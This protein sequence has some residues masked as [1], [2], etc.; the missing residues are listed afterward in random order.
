M[1]KLASEGEALLQDCIRIAAKD[2]PIISRMRAVN[3][4]EADMA[5]LRT[6]MYS[7]GLAEPTAEAYA[8]SYDD[9]QEQAEV[10]V[11]KI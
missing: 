10:A 3:K 7:P 2:E 5:E 8:S 6:A 1:D 9:L 11:A 4:S